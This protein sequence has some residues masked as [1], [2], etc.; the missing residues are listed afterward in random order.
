MSVLERLRL[1][2]REREK[3]PVDAKIER[4]EKEIAELRRRHEA[5]MRRHADVAIESRK[6]DE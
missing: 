6:V 2:L 3:G 5:R 1:A 4:R